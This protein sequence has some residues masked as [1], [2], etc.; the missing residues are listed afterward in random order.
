M[1][2]FPA[3]KHFEGLDKEQAQDA[4]DRM[5]VFFHGGKR[6][7]AASKEGEELDAITVRMRPEDRDRMTRSL[8]ALSSVLSER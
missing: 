1:N 7:H 2:H 3:T 6:E 5:R 8:A 4:F